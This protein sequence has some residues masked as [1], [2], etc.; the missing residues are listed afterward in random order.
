MYYLYNMYEDAETE[1]RKNEDFT[2]CQEPRKLTAYN[3]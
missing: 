1:V 3:I 2:S